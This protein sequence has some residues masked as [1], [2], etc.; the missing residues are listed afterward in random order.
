MSLSFTNGG[1]EQ[2]LSFCHM[3][4]LHHIDKKCMH[5][6]V[7]NAAQVLYVSCMDKRTF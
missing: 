2:K 1:R 4:E 5:T 6:N 7:V 3:I